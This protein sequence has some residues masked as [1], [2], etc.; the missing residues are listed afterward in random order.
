MTKQ[1][2]GQLS[3]LD[4]CQDKTGYSI[5]EQYRAEGYTNVY[6]R[7]PDHPCEVEVIDHEGHRFKS[8]AKISFGRMVFDLNKYGDQGH[9]ICWW[10]EIE[11]KTCRTCSQFFDYVCGL[12]EIYHGTACGKDRPFS[13][14]KAPDDPACDA[15]EEREEGEDE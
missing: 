8:V 4:L 7:M 11:Q 9:D 2:P 3:M 13:V 15:Y 10:R 6:D 14:D 12:G 5:G 1:I